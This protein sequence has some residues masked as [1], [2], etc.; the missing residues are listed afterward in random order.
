MQVARPSAQPPADVLA[1]ETSVERAGL[2]LA[3]PFSN[4]DEYEASIIQARRAAGAYGPKRPHLQFW[5]T[6]VGAAVMLAL[7]ASIT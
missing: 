7:L 3:C 1:L 6:V 2:A 5:L 4:S